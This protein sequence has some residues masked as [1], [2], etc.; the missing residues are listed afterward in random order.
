MQLGS[1][2]LSQV[3]GGSLDLYINIYLYIY[4]YIYIYIC[5]CMQPEG[6]L[7]GGFWCLQ[8]VAQQQ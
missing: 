2:H 5:V 4:S 6:S 7:V 3:A 1:N 8:P